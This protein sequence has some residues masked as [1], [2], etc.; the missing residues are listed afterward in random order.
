MHMNILVHT[1]DCTI[2]Y[3]CRSPQNENA[4]RARVISRPKRGDVGSDGCHMGIYA[5]DGQ[6]VNALRLSVVKDNWGFKEDQ[7][8]V[9]WREYIC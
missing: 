5:G 9:V 2:L 6:T 1:N 7:K 4:R 3:M 8:P